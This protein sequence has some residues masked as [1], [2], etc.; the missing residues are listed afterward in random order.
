MLTKSFSQAPPALTVLAVLVFLYVLLNGEASI[1]E[2]LPTFLPVEQGFVHVELRGD[3]LVSGVYQI[4]D[5][6]PLSAVIKLT[7]V[8]QAEF[9]SD[10]SDWSQ[11]L[12][13]GESFQIVKKD[14]KIEIIQRGWMSASHRVAMSIPLHPDRMNI[15]D[16]TFLPGIGAALA[17]RIENDRQENGDFGSL[18]AL[19]RVKGIGKKRISNWI[20]FFGDA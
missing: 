2:D 13:G 11:P 15:N 6:L 1:K 16:W 20:E 3:D 17:E 10:D 7:T 5:G 14:R 4:Y 12:H 19:I 8:S 9:L 18:D